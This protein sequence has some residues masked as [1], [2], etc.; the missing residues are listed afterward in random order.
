MSTGLDSARP[1]A[2]AALTAALLAPSPVAAST[3][4]V[5]VR[6]PASSATLADRS[7]ASPSLRLDYASFG[8]WVLSPT[9]ASALADAGI[10]HLVVD[11]PYALTL[12]GTRFDPLVAAPE[13]PPDWAGSGGAGDQ[14][15]LV[16]AIG[17][18]LPEWPDGLRAA[19][20][21]PLQYIHPFTY[22]VWGDGE[23]LDRTTALPWVRWR[24]DFIPAFRVLPRWRELGDPTVDVAVLIARV[25]GV[26][27]TVA[28][29]EAAGATIRSAAVL[30]PRWAVLGA[31]IPADRLAAAAAAPGVVT[32]QP[33]PTDGG[34]R[35]EMSNQVCAGNLG[36]G[37][38][39]VPGYL[40]WLAERGVDGD[41][42]VMANVDQ[43]VDENHL[44][45]AGQVL[46]CV[47]TTCGGGASSSHG[48]H[49]AGIQAATGASGVTS[50]G[51]LRGLGAAPGAR[52]VEQL[53]SPTFSLPGGMLLLVEESH[54]N[55]A[56]LSNNS[57][58][59]SGT[60]HGYDLDTMQTDIG[61]RDADPATPGNQGLTYVL[62]IMNGYGGTS[63]QG[64]PDE[65]KNTITVGSTAMQAPDGSQLADVDDLS[66][67]TAH[68]PALDGRTIP[69]LVAPGCRVDSTT[70]TGHG[71]ICG[72]SMSSP[73]VSGAAALL[74]E[75]WRT[76][77]GVDPSPA[78]VKAALTNAARDLAGHLDADGGVLGHPFDS[79]QG[80][81][82][83]DTGAVLDP[84]ADGDAFDG[85]RLL[86]TTGEEWITTMAVADPGQPVRVMLVWTDAPGH[87]LGGATPA[88]SND[89]DLVVEAA[90]QTYPGNRFGPDG[91]SIPGATADGMNNTEGVILPPGVSDRIT[92]R[93]RA[94]NLAADGVPGNAS[95][96]DQDFA[97]AIGNVIA[98]SCIP[99]PFFNGSLTA[100][101]IAIQGAQAFLLEWLPATPAC[102]GAVT[103]LV[104]DARVG[105][106]GVP[107]ATTAATARTIVGASPGEQYCFAVVP[108]EDGAVGQASGTVCAI[109]SAARVAGDL[110]CDAAV[111][112]ADLLAS[113][114]TLFGAQ[115]P[116]CAGY[117]A[118]DADLDGQLDSADPAQIIRAA[119]D[120]L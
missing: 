87:G 80:W 103:Y 66:S 110:D 98:G 117:P 3:G 5:V 65:A 22:L 96:T 118:G 116:S 93:V 55:G 30:D 6:L 29:L 15:R 75:G 71:L 34:A 61:V 7:G 1:I 25:A 63:S 2:L 28:E 105:N 69:H 57:W 9:A 40:G 46:P 100:S 42:V 41:G 89:L 106:P 36:G 19:G 59:P 86:T 20:L 113:V 13:V 44:D 4:G 11:E 115:E 23:A 16:Q 97:V 35:G 26:D 32:I 47:G 72:T 101:A 79:K 120:P 21:V 102:G 107:I 78:M 74:V 85:P 53:Y 67:N 119:D 82:R 18:I 12:G 109:G 54:A 31:T 38:L 99:G 56:V 33:V 81:G 39:A 104:N 76:S 91:R 70:P 83:L 49:T 64:T 52:L 50:L 45:L 48:T 60:P 43:G 84:A 17:P 111:T 58:G 62:S 24:G 51:F 77:R 112:T 14:L 73:H 37:G 88:W 68:G 92:V 114:A 10:P 108:L 94:V 95:A 27:R 90:G 8:W